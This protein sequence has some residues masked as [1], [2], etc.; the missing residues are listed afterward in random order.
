VRNPAGAAGVCAA[1]EL[2]LYSKGIILSSV[3][4]RMEINLCV[5]CKYIT[6]LNNTPDQIFTEKPN[7][8]YLLKGVGTMKHTQTKTKVNLAET[9][10]RR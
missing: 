7:R 8:T 10:I 6:T 1:M 3:Y 5:G 2:L 4:C 9:I